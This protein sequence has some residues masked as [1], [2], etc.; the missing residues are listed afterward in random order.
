MIDL[1]QIQAY[2]SESTEKTGEP[3]PSWQ[4]LDSDYLSCIGNREEELEELKAQTLDLIVE[5]REAR[6]LLNWILE[7]PDDEGCSWGSVAM[8]ELESALEATRVFLGRE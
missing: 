6:R 3:D 1:D 2:C 7:T 8:E 4:W 5:L